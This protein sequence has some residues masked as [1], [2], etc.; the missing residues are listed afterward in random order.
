MLLQGAVPVASHQILVSQAVNTGELD[1]HHVK[2]DE[3]TV[4]KFEPFISIAL[5]LPRSVRNDNH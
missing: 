1:L 4:N 2:G 5:F 3:N